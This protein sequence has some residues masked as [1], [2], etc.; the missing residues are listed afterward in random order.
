MLGVEAKPDRASPDAVALGLRTI[1]ADGR[2]LSS[3]QRARLH[4]G[5]LQAIRLGSSGPAWCSEMAWDVTYCVG[6]LGGV[7]TGLMGMPTADPDLAAAG[8][9]MGCLNMMCLQFIPMGRQLRAPA[10]ADGWMREFFWWEF[11]PEQAQAVIGTVRQLQ[12]FI[13][14]T[15][16]CK[17]V[18][19]V[20]SLR[21]LVAVGVPL[22]LVAA[23]ACYVPGVP[24]TGARIVGSI[25]VVVACVEILC[26]RARG[27]ARRAT[28]AS[29]LT[30]ADL[31]AE[32]NA[33]HVLAEQFNRDTHRVRLAVRPILVFAFLFCVMVSGVFALL[34][35][36]RRSE[37][38]LF[39]WIPAAYWVFFVLTFAILAALIVQRGPAKV[40]AEVE[41]LN[42]ALL[43]LRAAGSAPELEATEPDKFLIK[44]NTRGQWLQSD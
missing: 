30:G 3:D 33:V 27:L 18:I 39:G 5:V 1:A 37:N 2:C 25:T 22:V 8:G 12:L 23:T 38:S 14:F 4:P 19:L 16:I 35:L 7:A 10:A 32:R 9:F 13:A 34:T 40:I 24:I 15:V 20:W 43:S 17:L 29:L 11:T 28:A 31:D 44:Q 36:S 42:V 21:S 6:M 26:D 41:V